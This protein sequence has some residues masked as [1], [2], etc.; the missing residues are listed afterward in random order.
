MSNIKSAVMQIDA[1]LFEV[2]AENFA[3]QLFKML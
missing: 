3:Y 2:Y 1:Y